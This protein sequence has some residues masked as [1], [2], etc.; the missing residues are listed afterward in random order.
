M[1]LVIQKKFDSDAKRLQMGRQ[2]FCIIK[3]KK[4]NIEKANI[5]GI[6]GIVS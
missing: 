1:L 3:A 5:D 6:K 4:Y 2:K